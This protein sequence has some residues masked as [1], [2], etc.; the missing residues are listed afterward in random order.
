MKGLTAGFTQAEELSVTWM[1]A[2]CRGRLD[3]RRER[4]GLVI[5]TGDIDVFLDLDVGKGYATAVTSAGTVLVVVDQPASIG[6]L[7][8]TVA[9][10]HGL[11]GRLP[12]RPDDAPDRRRPLRGRG[13]DA[14]SPA[15]FRAR[16]G[17]GQGLGTLPPGTSTYPSGP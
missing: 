8:L 4:R 3:E 17:W 7:S 5:D 12:S 14:H 6:A 1:W 13:R 16:G 11:P 2:W 15:R 10:E 9:K